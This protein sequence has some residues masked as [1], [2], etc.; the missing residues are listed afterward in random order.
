MPE[1]L[2]IIIFTFLFLYY[3][4]FLLGI[5]FGLKRLSPLK[6]LKEIDEFVS[7]I[8]PFRNESDNI[9]KNLESIENQNYSKDKFEVIYVDDSSDDG[10]YKKLCL[11]KKSDN[12]K[13]YSVPEDYSPN[14]HKKKAV[15]FGIEKSKGEIIVTTDADCIYKQNWL[16]TLLSCYD[17]DTGFVS[18]PVEFSNGQDIFNK[19]Q[20][21]EFAGLILVGAGLIGIDKPAI[22]NAANAS[23]RRRAYDDV[24]GFADQL[25]LSSGDDELLMQKIWKNKNYQVKFCLNK[26]AIVSSNPNETLQEFYYQRKRWASKG[27]FYANKFL[28]VKLILIFLFYLTLAIQPVLGVILIPVFFISFL[29][30]IAGKILMEYLI[31]RKGAE[32]LFNKEMLK[33][34]L[35]AELLHIPY[36]ILF[37]LAGS[38]GGFEWKGRVIK[39]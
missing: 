34:F 1:I 20:R 5:Y 38:I 19:F 16:K 30:C 39:R 8:I 24:K 18:G 23:Y 15:R 22:C 4:N 33:P 17:E 36:I 28:V 31:L 11:V 37:G 3:A 26:E 27:L 14:A 35:I 12:I 25:N 9:L 10:S 6:E 7:V 32:I 2:L 13:V 29:V 21:L